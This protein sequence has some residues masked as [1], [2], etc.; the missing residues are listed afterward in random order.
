MYTSSVSRAIPFFFPF[1]TYSL[2]RTPS[3]VSY[4]NENT[5][6]EMLKIYLGITAYL[7]ICCLA[8]RKSK[9][10]FGSAPQCFWIIV[11]V[12]LKYYIYIIIIYFKLLYKLFSIAQWTPFYFVL[13]QVVLIIHIIRLLQIFDESSDISDDRTM[14]RRWPQIR[15]FG[16]SSLCHSFHTP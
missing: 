6:S 8:C 4:I 12:K 5:K 3:V 15:S 10:D 2:A 11:T 13:D 16:C 9:F 14:T 1:L 7:D